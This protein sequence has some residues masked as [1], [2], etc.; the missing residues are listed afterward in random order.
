MLR[1]SGYCSGSTGH[2]PIQDV[3][4]G[5]GHLSIGSKERMCKGLELED[6]LCPGKERALSS[7]LSR[8]R[9]SKHFS[10]L[11]FLTIQGEIKAVVLQWD[12]SLYSKSGTH[13]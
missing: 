12:C 11:H 2:F 3:V 13:C 10:S 5:S 1:A 6:I 8:S 4:C 7:K 9:K